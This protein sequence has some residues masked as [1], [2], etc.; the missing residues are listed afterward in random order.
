MFRKEES[1]WRACLQ[2]SFEL[3]HARA[4]D[5]MLGMGPWNLDLEAMQVPVRAWH[6]TAPRTLSP[7]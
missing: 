1:M 6:G 5:I 2:A 4:T 7:Q 3:E